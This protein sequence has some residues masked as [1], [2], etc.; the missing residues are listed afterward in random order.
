M[1]PCSE[2]G[3]NEEA[4]VGG[5]VPGRRQ[6]GILYARFLLNFFLDQVTLPNRSPPNKSLSHPCLAILQQEYVRHGPDMLSMLQY[7][8]A[9]RSTSDAGS[10]FASSVT[11]LLASFVSSPRVARYCRS[12][13]FERALGVCGPIDEVP[14]C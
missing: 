3:N 6:L 11:M 2:G 13:L 5:D 12:A 7:T 14:V 10:P 1:R 9:G 8:D 4:S